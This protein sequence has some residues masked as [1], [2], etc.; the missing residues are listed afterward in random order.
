MQSKI[1]IRITSIA[2]TAKNQYGSRDIECYKQ[3][4]KNIPLCVRAERAVL[5]SAKTALRFIHEI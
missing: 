3:M 4:K 5:G 2:C 1:K